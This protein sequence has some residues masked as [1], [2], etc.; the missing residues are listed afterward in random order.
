MMT[1]PNPGVAP[2]GTHGVR[3]D[4]SPVTD[5]DVASMADEAERG[6]DVDAVLRRRVGRPALGA[7]AAS[8]E[9]VR[10]EPDLKREL[11]LHAA[12]QQVSVSTVIRDAL[13]SYLH[14]S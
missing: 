14:A 7:G 9:S 10:L 4:G 12:A 11:L 13:R 1:A 3:A 6:F 2:R 5:V 8:V